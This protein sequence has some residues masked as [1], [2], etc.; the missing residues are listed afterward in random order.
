MCDKFQHFFNITFFLYRVNLE[1]HVF[2]NVI[3][4][5]DNKLIW[6]SISRQTCIN[7]FSATI[8]ILIITAVIRSVLFVSVCMKSSMVLHNN[9]FKALIK[10]TIYFFNTNPSGNYNLELLLNTT[11]QLIVFA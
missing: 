6:W 11:L 8:L 9:M 10:A 3:N 2:R 5:A 7:V 1:E 4:V